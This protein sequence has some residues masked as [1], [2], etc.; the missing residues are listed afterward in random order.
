MPSIRKL[1]L[2]AIAS[3][4]AETSPERCTEALDK[5]F[6]PS[7]ASD[8]KATAFDVERDGGV[9]P[10][11]IAC[12]KSIASALGYLRDQIEHYNT[13]EL[14]LVQIFDAWGYVTEKS[15]ESGN[16]AIHHA[17]A[18][19]FHTGVDVLEFALSKTSTTSLPEKCNN[20]VQKYMTL[21]SQPNENG[22]TPVM[23]AAVYGHTNLLKH[24]LKRTYELVSSSSDASSQDIWQSLGEVFNKRNADGC[25]ALNLACGHGQ[26]E[27]VGL[28]THNLHYLCERK[29]TTEL[30]FSP[31][32]NDVCN[33]NDYSKIHELTPLVM[34]TYDDVRRCQS[35][36]D[37]LEIGLKKM[38]HRRDEFQQQQKKAL[39]CLDILSKELDRVAAETAGLLLEN[40][41]TGEAHSSKN[42]KGKSSSK[43]KKKKRQH[44]KQKHQEGC[45][46]EPNSES[47]EG[48][49]KSH[50]SWR[51][52][53]EEKKGDTK[54]IPLA[55]TSPFVT[56]QDGRVVSK[57]QKQDDISCEDGSIDQVVRDNSEPKPLQSVLQSNSKYDDNAATTMESLCLDPS[58]LLLS[59]HRMAM[60][61]S[62]C[63]LDAIVSVLTKQFNASKEAQE[64]QSR[65]LR[66]NNK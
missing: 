62:P 10:L 23:M 39:E 36:I 42:P 58:M 49:D 9:T 50:N 55:A 60:E 11:M 34:V 57:S 8:G 20:N 46:V 33:L 3:L 22:D 19:N 40:E 28:L 53:I 59:A 54:L 24:V 56:L 26:V 5:I 27:I 51:I 45:H 47:T 43:K 15:Q 21:I 2:D 16:C 25:T 14:S 12:D 52:E 38:T 44:T 63:Q 6:T 65:L 18:A 48:V 35:T 29:D 30:K 32:N 7:L 13:N 41:N 64:I 4:D 17:M 1:L 31:N 37:N 61:L 66:N